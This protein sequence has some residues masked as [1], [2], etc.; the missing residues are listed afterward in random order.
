VL[1]GVDIAMNHAS[2]RDTESKG[3]DLETS[4][5]PPISAHMFERVVEELSEEHTPGWVDDVNRS[6]GVLTVTYHGPAATYDQ[7]RMFANSLTRLLGSPL[8]LIHIL[9][10]RGEPIEIFRPPP[11]RDP[12][13]RNDPCPCGSGRKYKNCHGG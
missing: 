7:L 10:E 4:P 13:G 5:M 6:D 12:V 1:D 8:P 9:D 11:R 3:L 2:I